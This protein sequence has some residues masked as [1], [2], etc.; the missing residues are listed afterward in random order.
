MRRLITLF[1]VVLLWTVPAAGAQ[2]VTFR[3]EPH[4]GLT[5]SHTGEL[6]AGSEVLLEIRNLPGN[7]RFLAS[8]CGP[9]CNTAESVFAVAGRDLDL[10][11]RTFGIDKT[12]R[13][14]F[15][16][17][18]RDETGAVGPVE[19]LAVENR[20]DGFLASFAGGCTI[21]GHLRRTSAPPADP[22]AEAPG[23]DAIEILSISPQQV[24][25]GVPVE[26]TVD[27]QVTLE[28]AFEGHVGLGF[29]GQ[30]P[31]R[32]TE[33]D[34]RTVAAGTQQLTFITEIVPVDWG[35]RGRFSVSAYLLP[36][37]GGNGPT[38]PLAHEVQPLDVVP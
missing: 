30:A 13:Y 6:E 2:S 18:K 7:E 37:A 9:D 36:R 17:Q 28:S 31:E 4:E 14:Y 21:R 10:M 8:R 19:I 5:F 38:T 1:G 35:D 33:A 23:K 11:S 15:Y 3:I 26:I 12:G 27:V 29:N 25:R 32:F 20:D 16:L 24:T 34:T 22:A